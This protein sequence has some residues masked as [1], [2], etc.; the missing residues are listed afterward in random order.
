MKRWL[1]AVAVL[2]ACKSG[3]DKKPASTEPAKL[4]PK[5]IADAAGS[6]SS[7]SAA[8][9]GSSGSVAGA[10]SSG[11]ATADCD[12]RVKKLGDRL[13]ALT[14]AKPGM[15]PV[16]LPAD[17]ALAGSSLGKP[18]DAPG[19]V[20]VVMKDNKVWAAGNIESIGKAVRLIDEVYWRRAREAMAMDQGPKRPW[21]LY[22]WADKNVKVGALG[23]LLSDELFKDFTLR[24][25]VEG[26]TKSEDAA[27]LDKPAVKKLHESLPKTDLEAMEARAKA[28]RASTDGCDTLP[29]AFAKSS[30]EAGPVNELSV[31]SEKI[32]AALTECKC[33]LA[34]W[35]VFEYS[36]LSIF[37]SFLPTPNY[38]PLGKLSAKDKR[39]VADLAVK[40]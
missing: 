16:V 38:V 36:M 22:I 34:D 17:V 15:L 23:K 40:P 19:V 2:C 33:N 27:I 14:A 10:G 4:E 29:M 25:L 3:E 12:V 24:L 1:V 30:T 18:I 13:R 39:T 20:I 9:A 35:D 21:P 28:L 26:E 11:A 6:G 31:M 8:G 7:G 32:T 5:A 37:G